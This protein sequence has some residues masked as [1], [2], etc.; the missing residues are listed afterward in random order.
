[1]FCFFNITVY[2][3]QNDIIRMYKGKEE[4]DVSFTA[5]GFTAILLH[6]NFNFTSVM[7]SYWRCSI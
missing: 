4:V 3:N 5:E 7:P 6:S 2:L 1:M